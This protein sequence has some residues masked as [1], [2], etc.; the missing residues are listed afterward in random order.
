MSDA[1]QRIGAAGMPPLF[2]G[3]KIDMMLVVMII[4]GVTLYAVGTFVLAV[5][6]GQFIH[7]GMRDDH[8]R[9]RRNGNQCE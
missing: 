6:I 7:A 9:M 8:E 5:F 1:Q 4:S 2:G 3:E